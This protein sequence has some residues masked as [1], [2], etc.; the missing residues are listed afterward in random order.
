MLTQELLNIIVCPTCKGRLQTDFEKLHLN[1]IP[2][3]LVFQVKDGIPVM[4]LDE[5]IKIGDQESSTKVK[6]R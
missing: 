2:C 3:G 4:L 6:D 1:C 5:A